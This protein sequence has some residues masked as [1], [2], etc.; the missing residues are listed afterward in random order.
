M[1]ASP[2]DAVEKQGKKE[3]EEEFQTAKLRPPPDG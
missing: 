1:L 3:E 2:L